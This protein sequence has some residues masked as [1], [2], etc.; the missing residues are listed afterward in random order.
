MAR[1]S[2]AQGSHVRPGCLPVV[3]LREG[4]GPSTLQQERKSWIPAFA[5]MTGECGDDR[6]W[7]A[8][9]ISPLGPAVFLSSSS[10]N[11]SAGS[12]AR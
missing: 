11:G 7:G 5:G 9:S 8:R 12:A 10:A 4:G 3:V 6:V 1:C 2:F